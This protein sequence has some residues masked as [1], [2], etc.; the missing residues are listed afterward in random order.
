MKLF[1]L[2][3]ASKLNNQTA[4]LKNIDIKGI[5][6]NSSQIEE[7]H[8]FVAIKGFERDGHVYIQDAL[9]RGAA[10]IIGENLEE[11]IE[12]PY[13][14]VDNS[15]KCLAQLAAILYGYPAQ[16][17]R[18]IGVTGT[19]GKTTTSYFIRHLLR[20]QGYT[21]G[22]IGTVL[23][24]I[25]G[26]KIDSNNT[27]PSASIIQK[28]L[29]ESNDD[30]I[31][32]E[33]SSQGLDQYRMEGVTFDYALFTNLQK[34]HLMYHKTMENY[35]KAK[36]QLFHQL[37]PNGQAIVNIEDDWGKKL[38]T[39]LEERNINYTTIAKTIAADYHL[40][41]SDA[42]NGQ[43]KTR[44]GL[45][46][47]H[48]PMPGE[49][50]FYNMIMA[51]AVL[52][53]IGLPLEEILEDSM[54]LQGVPGRFEVYTFPKDVRVVI[55]YAHTTEAVKVLMETVHNLQPQPQVTHVFGFRS[56]RDTFKWEKMLKESSNWCHTIYLTINDLLGTKVED[57]KANYEK[58][59]VKYPTYA[60]KVKMDRTC[61]IEEAIEQAPAHSWVVITGK[62][63]KEYTESFHLPTESDRETVLHLKERMMDAHVTRVEG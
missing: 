19:N 58:L 47:I 41:F 63:H 55:D 18:I 11:D 1:D 40:S 20:S 28:L 35:F 36:E 14:R 45:Y 9:D 46:A 34:D 25:N 57:L 38:V 37:K 43:V 60:I 4:H 10:L 50:N 23:N 5:T 22:F 44:S 8:I 27:T 12:F 2:L 30:F 61:A 17:K 13:I 51:A 3:Q 53:K 29:S 32:I 7:G 24:E 6:E 26:R 21:V 16:N 56:N 33:V 39:L 49:H 31:V 54:N 48:S 15:R 59:A 42:E 62:G 52:E